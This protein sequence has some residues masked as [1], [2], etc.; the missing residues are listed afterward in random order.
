MAIS[1]R[2]RLGTL[3]RSI[4]PAAEWALGWAEFYGV[5]VTVTSG[6]RSLASQARLR[7]KFEQCVAMG[8]FPSPPDCKFPANRPG[9][10]AHNFSLAWDST[11]PERYMPWW[12][13]V[14]RLAGFKVPD[15]DL[16][17]AE[18]PNWRDFVA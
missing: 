10:S 15:G 1:G 8:R 16:I 9:E 2:A 12:V 5:P 6:F 7:R 17:H 13:H 4:K 3:D 18:H 11:V 14:R